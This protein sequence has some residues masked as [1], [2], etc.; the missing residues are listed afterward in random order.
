MDWDTAT[1]PHD[2]ILGTIDNQLPGSVPSGRGGMGL[3][4]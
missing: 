4:T 2:N 3:V 1:N